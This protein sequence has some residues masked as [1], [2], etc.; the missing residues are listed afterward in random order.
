[1]ACGCSGRATARRATFR[2]ASAPAKQ[3]AQ[4]AAQ[5]AVAPIYEVLDARGNVT[6][7]RFTSMVAAG[8]YARSIGGTTRPAA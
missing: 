7:R 5:A 2:T 4:R 8:S 1:M 6:Q 3:P